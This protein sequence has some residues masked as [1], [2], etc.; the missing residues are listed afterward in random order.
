MAQLTDTRPTTYYTHQYSGEEID[1]AV[2]RALTG[3]AL[4]TS[5]T[6]VSN[7]LGTF[8]RPNLLDNWYFGS[9]VDQR[10]GYIQIGGTMMYKDAAC[11][12]QFGPSSGTT[13]VVVYATYARPI[14]HGVELALYIPLTSIVR[15]YTGNGYG[16]DRWALYTDGGNV[17]ISNGYLDIYSSKQYGTYLTQKIDPELAKALAGKTVT[18]S[19]L[20][21]GGDIAFSA[22]INKDDS[23]V[24]SFTI[25][26]NTISFKTFTFP[27]DFT[28]IS[29][30][31]AGNAVGHVCP[32]AAKLEL[33]P[34]Q[35]L[36]HQ[37][38][39]VWV[40]NEV[41]EYGGQLAG[42]Q[43]Y[44]LLSQG[45][46]ESVPMCQGFIF[47]PTP[48]TMRSKPVIVGAPSVWAFETNAQIPDA[49]VSVHSI[50][51]NG[52]LLSTTATVPAYV[53]FGAG[54]GLSADL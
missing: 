3:G 33:G 16:V 52:V 2:G 34:T 27:T 10:K 21:V 1:A 23:Y 13:P 45:I 53:Y 41:P 18:W 43:R 4:D 25:E 35:T 31:F 51:P 36:A 32:I 38:N 47:V 54:S 29:F 9:P 48:V 15:G 40:L 12:D 24:D 30:I 6:N 49:T 46:M 17:A 37:E 28:D 8:V 50:M 26:P 7:Q 44:A 11:T 5:V 20:A 39:G 19:V 42:C 22:N 14:D